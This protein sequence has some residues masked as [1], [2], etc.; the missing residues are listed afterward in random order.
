VEQA[1]D[2]IADELRALSAGCPRPGPRYK[3]SCANDAVTAVLRDEDV[4][5]GGF[6][7]K[8]ARAPKFPPA[9]LLEALLRH[10]ERTGRAPRWPPCSAPRRRWPRWHL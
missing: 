7:N 4:E 9:M 3:R 2:E 1:S 5:R 10:H 8:R 6:L